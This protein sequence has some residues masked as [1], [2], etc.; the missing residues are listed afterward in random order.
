ML[1]FEIQ[2]VRPQPVTQT[3]RSEPA[4]QTVRPEPVEGS[5]RTSPHPVRAEL[6]FPIILSLSKEAMRSHTHTLRQAQ[7]ERGAYPGLT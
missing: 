3:V 7:G 1:R 2:T 6:V 4:T 5:V